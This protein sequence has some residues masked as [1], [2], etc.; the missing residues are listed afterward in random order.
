VDNF[1]E[2]RRDRSIPEH[3]QNISRELGNRPHIWRKRLKE[4]GWSLTKSTH[5]YKQIQ[6]GDYDV[7]HISTNRS[8]QGKIT[9]SITTV[10]LIQTAKNGLHT[11]Q[12]WFNGFN[13][14][15]N[16]FILGT[17]FDSLSEIKR[18]ILVSNLS[19]EEKKSLEITTNGESV[20]LTESIEQ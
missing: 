7:L 18:A 9:S 19:S 13:E 3:S 1:Q 4:D 6:I 5:D 2:R 11:V 12:F 16:S 10:E 15:L 20:A 14:L 17:D 8:T